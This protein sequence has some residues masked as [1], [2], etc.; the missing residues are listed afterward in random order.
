M[1]PNSAAT[2]DPLVGFVD[3]CIQGGFNTRFDSQ[4][5]REEDVSLLDL[6][7][8]I[9]LHLE[10]VRKQ[11]GDAEPKIDPQQLLIE[12]W[13]MLDEFVESSLSPEGSSLVTD[14]NMQP[15]FNT[16][17]RVRSFAPAPTTNA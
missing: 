10:D 16:L 9:K 13:K 3:K 1:Q 15:V 11:E 8:G 12:T 2:I 17:C 14:L 6:F 7:R 4:S 5:P